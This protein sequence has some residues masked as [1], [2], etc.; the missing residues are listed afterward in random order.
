MQSMANQQIILIGV[1]EIGGV[2]A[3][4][5]LRLGYS[6]HPVNRNTD[7]QALSQQVTS[8]A[9]VV[10]AVGEQALQPV[11]SEIPDP[12]RDRLCLL[13]NELLPQDWQGIP[14]PTVI[15][16]W[17]EK[18]PGM[19]AK[20]IIPSPLF[21]PGTDLLCAALDA[22]SIPCQPLQSEA[23]LLRELVIKNLYI[24]TTNIAGL[25]CGGTVDQLWRDHRKLAS[26]VAAEVLALQEALTGHRFDREVMIERMLDAFAGDPEHKC[27]GRSAPVRLTRALEHA[28]RFGLS[29]PILE[30]IAKQ[31][32]PVS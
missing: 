31:T 11:L 29:L 27:M 6:V 4:G 24:L 8:P 23:E 18:K 12:W 5:F 10:V 2:F 16:I 1:G 14:Q 15:S 21:G 17:F 30:R 22:V 26:A 9:L 3:R 28:A 7:M 32:R 25:E 19:D 13:Q 20:V